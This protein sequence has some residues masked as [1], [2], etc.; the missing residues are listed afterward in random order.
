MDYEVDFEKVL[1][2][3]FGNQILKNEAYKVFERLDNCFKGKYVKFNHYIKESK[4]LH[5][6]VLL[7]YKLIVE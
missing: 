3:D 7:I 1:L 6:T 2:V 4:M 5:F